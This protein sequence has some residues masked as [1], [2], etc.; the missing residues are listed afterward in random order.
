MLNSIKKQKT[1][2]PA[3]LAIF[4]SSWLLCHSANALEV[5]SGQLIQTNDP[6]ALEASSTFV[7]S[8]FFDDLAL[9]TRLRND[10]NS[11]VVLGPGPLDTTNFMYSLHGPDFA[12]DAMRVP[13]INSFPSQFEFSANNV[14]QSASAG[15]IG[16]G[17][18]MRFDLPPRDDGTPRYFMMGDWTLEYDTSRKQDYNFAGD[19]NKPIQPAD[20]EVSGWILR[21][22][23][24][25]PTISYDVLKATIFS[26]SD[27]FYLSG[28][29]GWSPE[30]VS[31]FFPEE[32]LYR[33]TAKFVM[34]AQDDNAFAEQVAAQ[35]PCVFPN[36]TLNGQSGRV[37]ISAPEQIKL[38]VDLGV[39]TTDKNLKADYF[40]AFIYQDTLYWLNQDFKWT[41]TASAVYQGGLID[42]RN[43]SIPSPAQVIDSLPSGTIIPVYFGVD[44]TQNGKFDEP[45]RYSS[46]TLS[47]D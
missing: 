1:I 8:D 40:A 18:V 26:N 21:N 5:S 15:R 34:C 38:A 27:S 2:V 44:A 37:N 17:G 13:G 6:E 12:S 20:Y 41:T 36:I 19:V 39:A 35:I 25:F 23:I 11:D 47:I 7:V 28:E 33:A 32:E 16:L 43:I 46:V 30:I 3:S 10:L 29:L 24:D 42:F 14:L 4:C 22:H 9:S 45:Y 31:A